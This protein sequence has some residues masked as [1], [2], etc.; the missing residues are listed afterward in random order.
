MPE[1]PPRC[2]GAACSTGTEALWHPGWGVWLPGQQQPLPCCWQRGQGSLSSHC[3]ALGALR[4]PFPPPPCCCSLT[5]AGAEG[6]RRLQPHRC[7]LA[8][9]P[10]PE[11]K[12]FSKQTLN[13]F[14]RQRELLPHRSKGH[15]LSVFV[16][17][18]RFMSLFF[19]KGRE[20]G[21]AVAYCLARGAGRERRGERGFALRGRCR[22][23]GSAAALGSA[24]EEQRDGAERGPACGA[25]AQGTGQTGSSSLRPSG[26][27]PGTALP[28]GREQRLDGADRECGIPQARAERLL[29]SQ[30]GCPGRGCRGKEEGGRRRA[31]SPARLSI[32]GTAPALC[33]VAPNPPCAAFPPRSPSVHLLPSAGSAASAAKVWLLPLLQSDLG[34]SWCLWD[35]A[36]PASP[37]TQESNSTTLVGPFQLRRFHGSMVL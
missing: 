37:L 10:L 7:L 11:S 4:F 30:P 8:P 24:G 17:P 27:A 34:T 23:L 13:S 36:D 18:G 29:Q 19:K 12:S 9:E 25:G 6:E 16:A 35:G 21:E 14:N 32:P 31:G 3:R 15:E 2:G 5:Q 1:N 28:A 26:R 33:A 20:R 22:A